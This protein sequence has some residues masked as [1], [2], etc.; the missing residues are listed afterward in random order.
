MREELIKLQ[1][2]ILAKELQFN[3]G[4]QQS[5]HVEKSGEVK[6]RFEYF[7]NNGRY[8]YSDDHRTLYARPTQA[9]LQTWIRKKF[10]VDIWV[11]PD[12]K[13]Y[14]FNIGKDESEELFNSY[15]E[16]L[17]EGLIL[18]MKK[19]KEIKEKANQ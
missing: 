2:A 7:V 4:V 8:D 1:A 14:Y 10:G 12:D 17:E 19:L 16:A 6:N 5:F 11:K 15:E 18:V 9:F 3:E 13:A